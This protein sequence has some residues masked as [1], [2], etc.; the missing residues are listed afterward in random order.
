MIIFGKQCF[1]YVLCKA[2]KQIKEIY[3]SKELNKDIFRRL[4]QLH[5]PIFRIDNKKAQAMAHGRNHQ[6]MFAKIQE[7][8]LL[9][10]KDILDC[11]T[12]VVL[13]GLTDMGNIGSIVRTA[14]ALGVCGVLLCDRDYPSLQIL[15]GI[16]RASSGALLQMPLGFCV[17]SLEFANQAKMRGFTL[18]G[19]GLMPDS[20][21][22]SRESLQKWAL[23][24]GSE[25][26]GLKQKLLQKMDIVLHI[27]MHN[28]FDS[29]NVS[30]ATGILIDR[31]QR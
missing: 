3:L 5:V 24:I 29:L 23:F 26:R 10:T 9:S 20:A 14:Y 16:F 7:I 27:P 30:V 6:G 1:E 31:I 2:P 15:E 22:F 18:L 13:S 12:L 28:N 19:T 21:H 4:Q 17:T 11:H 25:D 8:P